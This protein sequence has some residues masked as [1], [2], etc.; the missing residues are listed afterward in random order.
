M[1]KKTKAAG[2][3]IPKV[4]AN[5]LDE[6]D[7]SLVQP[8]EIHCLGGFVMTFEYGLARPTSDVDYLRMFPADQSRAVLQLAGKSSALHQKYGLYLQQVGVAMPP[9]NYE[10][11]LRRLFP[12]RFKNLRLMGLDPYDLALSKLERNTPVDR[13]DVKYLCKA[14][15]LDPNVLRTRYETELRPNLGNPNRD[16]L[17]LKLWLEAFFPDEASRAGT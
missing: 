17:T 13:D 7:A 2:V 14:I 6:L 15:P 9:E 4:W 3:N 8:V 10:S 1:P 12:G 5:F 16:D 11:R